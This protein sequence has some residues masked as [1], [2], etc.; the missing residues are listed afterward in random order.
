MAD[1]VA[2][3][4]IY[5]PN[6]QDGQWDEKSGNRRVV[7]RLTGTSDGTGETDI[8]KIILSDLKTPAGNIPQRTVVEWIDWSVFG[9][10]VKLEWDRTP[11]ALIIDMNDIGF[12]NATEDSGFRS[13]EQY[14]GLLDP[15]LDDGTG[16]II[17]TSENG[18]SGDSYDITI[19]L[20][21]KD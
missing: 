14:G 21:L 10:S 12:N 15:G 20:R 2:V 17:L 9:M 1:T 8:A 11:N 16:N 5:P 6:M 13:W 7:A 19:C 4:W 3:Q 18:F